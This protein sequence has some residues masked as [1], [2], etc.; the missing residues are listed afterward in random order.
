M[1]KNDNVMKYILNYEN[2]QFINIGFKNKLF[3][4]FYLIGYKK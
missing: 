2:F 3:S 1:T 4:D